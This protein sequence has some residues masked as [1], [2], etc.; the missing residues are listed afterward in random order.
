MTTQAH[1]WGL[2]LSDRLRTAL[3]DGDFV[4]AALLA[5]DGDGHARSLAREFTFMYRGLGIAIRVIMN[6]LPDVVAP[7][8]L[9]AEAAA[10]VAR[11]RTELGARIERILELPMPTADSGAD[12]A[13]EIAK[14]ETLLA[15]GEAGFEKSQ[16]A[17]AQDILASLGKHDAVRARVLINRKERE[18]YLPLHDRL[19]RFMADS[20][21]FVYA[22]C[23]ADA[24]LRFHLAT[25]EAQRA[26][27][28]KWEEMSPEDFAKTSAFLLK[29]HMGSLDVREDEEKFTFDQT[30][31]GSGGRLQVNGA[32]SGP[33][34]LPYVEEA[35]KLTFGLP[36]F[37]VY[38]SHCP[39]WNG[40]A[41]NQWFGHSQ[42][43][44][45]RPAQPDGRCLLHIYKK[46]AA[47]PAGY[48]AKLR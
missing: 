15:A 21:G 40:V 4:G 38:C 30:L 9:E 37:P 6:A 32:Y 23:G 28:T 11:F 8:Q 26:G 47:V 29:Q 13:A 17:L 16:A 46:P 24:L 22:R 27:F 42:W 31:C 36:H 19:V 44:F 12:L 25:A 2:R 3:E 14:A 35:G 1:D 20:W 39:V 5:R 41:P 45:E 48:E 18:H 34:G 7:F 43:V 10:L 33:D